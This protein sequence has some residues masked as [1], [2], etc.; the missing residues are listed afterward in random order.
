MVESWKPGYANRVKYSIFIGW[1]A[2]EDSK[3]KSV[4]EKLVVTVAYKLSD[5]NVILGLIT[6]SLTSISGGLWTGLVQPKNTIINKIKYLNNESG[7]IL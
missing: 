7:E 5:E 1:C 2:L 6:G 3:S 4:K